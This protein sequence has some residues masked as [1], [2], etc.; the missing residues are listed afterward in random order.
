MKKSS[1]IYV[2]GHNGMVG[3]AVCRF[4]ANNGYS[5]I[6]TRSST[7]LDLRIQSDVLTFLEQE[8][9]AYVFVAAARVGGIHANESYP[10]DF[11]YENLMIASNVIHSSYLMKVKKLMFFGSSCMYPKLANQPIKEDQLLTSALE[12]TNEP[13]AIAKIAGVKLCQTYKRQFGCD[14]FSVVPANLFGVNDTYHLQNSHVI[15]SL[16]RRFHEAKMEGRKVVRL[17]G[18]G[19]ARREFLFA[20]DLAEASVF[21]MNKELN[22][23]VYNVGTGKDMTIAELAAMIAEVTGYNGAIDWDFNKPNGTPRKLLDV[24]KLRNLG[25]AY[26]TSLRKGLELAYADFCQKT[27]LNVS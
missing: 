7:V 26:S 12:A 9:P 8:K 10:A 22:D 15:P 20:D 14:Y 23:E 3:S 17:W 1:K 6:I 27:E 13:Y 18:T 2:A 21:L 4:L 24:S 25:W 19:V 16:I 11:L 5:N